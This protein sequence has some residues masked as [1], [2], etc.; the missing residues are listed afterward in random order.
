MSTIRSV[1]AGFVLAVLPAAV[2]AQQ[3]APSAPPP[4][5]AQQAT[6]PAQPAQ[7]EPA[8]PAADAD[9]APP[10][11]KKPGEE[12]FIPSEELSPD[13]EVTFPVDI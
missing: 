13:E 4:A 7:A 2:F 3:S 12:E 5:A 11:V 6:Q 9:Q 8:K 10:P 1:V